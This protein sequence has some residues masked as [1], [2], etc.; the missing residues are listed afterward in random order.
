M[1]NQVNNWLIAG[2]GIKKLTDFLVLLFGVSALSDLSR[3]IRSLYRHNGAQFTVL[4]LKECKRAVEH[5]CSGG[6]LTNTIS[7]PFV[8]LRKGLPSFLPADLRK[9]IRSGDRV[10]VMLT[11]TLL[12]L[13]RG[14]V[15]PPNVK[16]E[17]ITDGYSGESD[18]LLG[19][20]D[21]VE[22]FLG[23]LQIGKLK[24]PRLWLSTSVGPHGMM[25][26]VSAIR[27]A[28]SLVSGVHNTI[29]LFQEEYAKAVYGSRY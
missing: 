11:L 15:V 13:Y 19:F 28:A 21:T 16:V 4:Y 22:R 23:Q 29:R 7:P 27:D 25:G 6:A 17:T 5:F 2:G 20:S 24:R 18:H 10:G 9:R 12:G 26:S 3:S 8:G 14:L 1:L